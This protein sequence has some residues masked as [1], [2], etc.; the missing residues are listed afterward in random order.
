[1]KRRLVVSAGCLM[2]ALA[3]L[4]ADERQARVLMQAAEAKATVQGD[5]K[6][7]IAMYE[8]AAKEAGTNRGLVAQA[9]LRMA[10]CYQKL[11][12]AQAQ[13]IY[14]RVVR[15][16]ADQG[17][18]V[19]LARA[20]MDSRGSRAPVKSERAVWTSQTVDPFGQVSPDGRFIT[21]V[22][23][24]TEPFNVAY[25]DLVTNTDHRITLKNSEADFGASGGFSAISRDSKQV[26]YAWQTRGDSSSSERRM[27]NVYIAPLQEDGHRQAR[28]L[29][30]L[31]DEAT[32]GPVSLFVNPGDWS[33]D[34]KWIALAIEHRRDRAVQIALASVADGSLR[35]LKTLDWRGGGRVFFS[36]DGR[37]ITYSQSIDD[38]TENS[39]VKVMAVDGSRELTA[40]GHQSQ[41]RPLGWSPDGS[42]LLFASNRTGSIGIWS[43]AIADGKP[44]AE[45]ELLKASVGSVTP[46]GVTDSG[47]LYVY[48]MVGDR[49]IRVASFDAADGKVGHG[50]AWPK[51]FT[52]GGS[53]PEWSPDGKQ[54]A[55]SACDFHCIVIRST[56]TGESRQLPSLS[57]ARPPSWSPDGRSLLFNGRDFKGRNGIF[58]ADVET[59]QTTPVVPDVAT[60]GVLQWS[61]DGQRIYYVYNRVLHERDLASGADREMAREPGM[62]DDVRLSPDGKFIAAT[63]GIDVATKVSRLILIPTMGGD[64]REVMRLSPPQSFGRPPRTIAWLPDSSAV[65]VQ[66]TP[67]DLQGHAEMWKVPFSGGAPRKLET[68]P[69]LWARGGG[70]FDR[71]FS[72]SR[73]GRT[74]TYLTGKWAPEVWTL[75]N[76]LPA[77]KK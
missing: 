49:D 57:Y 56:E 68:D 65:L 13:R 48:R 71:G 73:D 55:Y 16:Y 45:P 32:S 34:G 23:W 36:P 35:V 3:S 47:A 19:I 39:H 66:T 75:E 24:S 51:G 22:D 14:E 63:I 74:I 77:P 18:V 44:Q 67:I 41:N 15:D 28:L 2:L 17:Q 40:V 1:M 54:I 4:H 38:T 43:V 53:L 11:G 46:L 10:D 6:A 61:A 42:H 5:L 27:Q 33:P 62:H 58:L 12:D 21:F 8:Q 30:S 59:G 50:Q 26:A 31:K 76:F 20:R 70:W 72:L 9:L 37:Y 25:R 7:A 69:D 52:E 29:F 60:Q 64:T